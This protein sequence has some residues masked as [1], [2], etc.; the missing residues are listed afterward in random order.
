MKDIKTEFGTLRQQRNGEWKLKCPTCGY[1][2]YLDDDQF[3]GRVSVDH[4]DYENCT[5]HETHNFAEAVQSP[6]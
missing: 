1:W 2:G 5:Y 3:N 4:T 6:V